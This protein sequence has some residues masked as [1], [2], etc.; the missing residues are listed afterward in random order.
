MYVCMYVCMYVYVYIYIYIYMHTIITAQHPSPPL[1]RPA[2][3]A[4]NDP[5]ARFCSP[6]EQEQS[7][8]IAH[9]CFK[10]GE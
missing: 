4:L 2:S 10:R 1:A 3:E 8:S 9:A 6:A 7:K 5:P